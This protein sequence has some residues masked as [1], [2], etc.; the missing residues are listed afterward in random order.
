M[1]TAREAAA[2]AHLKTP[3]DFSLHK[4]LEVRIWDAIANSGTHIIY[5]SELPQNVYNALIALG[6]ELIVYST[7]NG[8]KIT[9]ISW[10]RT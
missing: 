8:N 5:G 2:T 10:E 7:D 3:S 9:K 6:Y 1:L 4:H